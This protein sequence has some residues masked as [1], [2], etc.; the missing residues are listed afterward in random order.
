[1]KPVHKS[2]GEY[3]NKLTQLVALLFFSFSFVFAQQQST[4]NLKQL[5]PDDPS[6]RIGKL[7]NGLT[8]IIKQN[9]KPEKRASFRLAVNAGAILE[10][11]DQNGLAHF[12]EHMAFNGT[13]N[14][15]KNEL[16]NY[17]ES[18]GTRF[19]T[20]L[21]AGTGQD[22]TVYMLQVRTDDDNI[23]EK[24]FVVFSDWAH[25]QL[26]DPA[27]IEKER[28]VIL[29]EWRLGRGAEARMSDKQDPVIYKGSKYAVRNV[30][31]D[32]EVILKANRE[33]FQRFYN[34]WYRPDLMAFVVVGDFDVD[35]V[36]KLIVKYFA[37]IPKPVNPKE[38]K[39]FE[40]PDHKETLFAIASDKEA[41]S[42]DV[43]VYYKMDPSTLKTIGDF[44]QSL[45]ISLFNTMNNKRFSELTQLADPPF[46]SAYSYKGN[47]VRSKGAYIYMASVKDNGIDK[48]LKTILVEAERVKKYGFTATEF[49]RTKNEI[50]RNAEKR[51]T[52]KDKMESEQIINTYAYG[53]LQGSR[54][55]SIEDNYKYIKELLPTITLAEVN[56]LAAKYIKDENRVI[57]VSMPEKAGVKVPAESDLLAVFEDAKKT[58]V[59]PYNDNFS[60][61]PLVPVEP[62]TG[63]VADEKYFSETGITQL[64]LSNGVTVI[65]KP[66]DFKNDEI[67]FRAF[68]PGGSSQLTEQEYYAANSAA[69]I[70]SNSG[71]GKFDRPSLT[72]KLSGKIANV[73]PYIGAYEE[74]LNGGGSPK[75]I[76]TMFQLI[77]SYFIQPRKD[78][79]GF[80][81]YLAQMKAS[82]ENRNAA[83]RMALM[84]TLLA[85]LSNRH[86]AN[87]PMTKELLAKIDL[88]KVYN[89]YKERFA[90]ASD[91]TFVFT[92]SFT[93]ET[94]LPLIEK[95]IASLPS[96]NR[97]ETWKDMGFRLAKGVIHKEVKKGIEP[98]SQVYMVFSGDFNFSE[99][100]SYYLKS[101]NEVLNIKL[102]EAVREEKGGTYGISCYGVGSDKPYP[103]YQQIITFGCAPER[104][105]ELVKT[106][107][108]TIEKI[109]KE[110]PEATDIAKVKEI[111]LRSREVDLKKNQTWL[112]EIYTAAV[113]N[114]DFKSIINYSKYTENLDSKKIQEACNTYFNMNNY[115]KVVLFP[116]NK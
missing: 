58:A 32:K 56:E 86:Y 25:Y 62:K 51:L 38:R 2:F 53:F 105:D 64:K 22:Q 34:D 113:Y 48:G 39:D 3:M 47:L 29:E 33:A 28:G 61:D 57:A 66:T 60:N 49:E 87:K 102:R 92:G 72:K 40:V 31:G 84:D 17:L 93:K 107:F 83:P 6:V 9:K 96:I 12:I 70:I 78:S 59:T 24:A 97:K 106:V 15:K 54:N 18:V 8:Y 73:S 65:L 89:F 79:T 80:L 110:G 43:T 91:F 81:S 115:I 71:I 112:S 20:D 1:M 35:K 16:I 99:E 5:I 13:K 52:E 21:N 74:G 111:Q 26:L 63:K 27:E 68:S 4:L 95:Y 7:E 69:G 14:F 90:D 67:V 82:I 88:N 44:R 37:E 114:R 75:D 103:L 94:I 104:V 30:I 76:V 98:Q 85:V 108:D 23:F 109:K 100:N 36:E 11:D 42:T 116:E 50:L 19:G 46:L 101:M 41:T 10:D 77:H 45:V 55:P